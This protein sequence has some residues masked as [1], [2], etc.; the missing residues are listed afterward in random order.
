MRHTREVDW[1]E[2]ADRAITSVDRE[3][4]CTETTKLKIRDYFK[5]SA[6]DGKYLARAGGYT[7]M[8]V[9]DVNR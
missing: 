7:G 8:M 3:K 4:T 5:T 1:E 6:V 9:W 2:A